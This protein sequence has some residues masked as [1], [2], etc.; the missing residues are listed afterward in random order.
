MGNLL[1]FSENDMLG[2]VTHVDTEQIIIEI[3]NSNLMNKICVGTNKSVDVIAGKI[4]PGNYLMENLKSLLDTTVLSQ[5]MWNSIRNAVVSMVLNVFVCSL[6]GYGFEKFHDKYKDKIMSILLLSMMVPTAAT[7]IPLFRMFGTMGLL[8]TT[9]GCI[10][11]TISTAF[12]IFMFRQ[13]AKSFPDKIIEAAR[14]DGVGEWGIY[15]KMFLPI[16]KSTYAAAAIVSF[17]NA[18][19]SYMWPLI[20]LQNENSKTMPILVSGL[21]ARYTIDYGSMMLAVTISTI[22]MLIIFFVLQKNF[23]EGMTGSV[24]S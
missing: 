14:I 9:V 20:V 11:P 1:V 16:M 4:L 18:W 12:M 13:A 15:F 5:A 10:L 7:V 6:A 21:T 22:P 2:H 3:E 23:V 19:N 24:K 8:N 17:M